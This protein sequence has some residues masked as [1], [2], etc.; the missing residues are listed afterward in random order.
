MK[1]QAA[2]FAMTLAAV[3]IIFALAIAP[4]QSPGFA[5]S[6]STKT[7]NSSTSSGSNTNINTIKTLR[8]GYYPNIN[9]AQ[10][11]IGFGN[12]DFQKTLGANIKVQTFIFNT[13]PSAIEA[14]LAKKID[15]TYVGSNPPV[16]GYIVSE[17]KGIRIIAGASSNE[18]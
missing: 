11:V 9:H 5:Q 15:V 6:A 4:I 8:I 13:G 10:A 16:N 18:W 17:G 3:I 14:L 2:K 12:G 1:P 7:T